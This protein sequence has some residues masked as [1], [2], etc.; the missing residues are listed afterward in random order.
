MSDVLKS[1]KRGTHH[2]FVRHAPHKDSIMKFP[3]LIYDQI[4]WWLQRGKYSK[5]EYK[6]IDNM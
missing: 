1:L 3:D 4:P 2:L 6:F 5:K